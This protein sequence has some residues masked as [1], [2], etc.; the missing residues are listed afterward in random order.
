M[1]RPTF[2]EALNVVSKVF[3]W[4]A[5]RPNDSYEISL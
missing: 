4:Y 5:Y 1:R 3:G 2:E